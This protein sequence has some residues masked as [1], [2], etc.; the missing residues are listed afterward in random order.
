[1]TAS[2]FL[3]FL[4]V[5]AATVLALTARYLTRR[6]ALIALAGLPLWLAYVGLLAYS[7]VIRN[8]ALRPPGIVF[9]V[10]PVILFV[11]IFFVRSSAGARVALAFPLWIIL[12]MQSFRIG[13][14]LLLHRLW[15]DG[16]VPRMLTYNGANLD[17]LAGL[18]APLAA[19]AFTKGR[20]GERFALAWNVFGLLTLAN[21]ITRSVLTAPG[22]LHLIDTEVPN[23]AMGIFPFTY[24]AGFFA[25]LAMVLHVMAIRALRFQLSDAAKPV[26][27]IRP[28]KTVSLEGA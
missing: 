27:A 13:V 22:P 16:L 20:I 2:L 25:P 6:T 5:T 4:A 10:L 1:M 26:P 18:S 8:A 7:G 15:L 9:V 3:A 12:G 24:I 28:A 17:I 14:E 19:W 23:L 21:I 11:L